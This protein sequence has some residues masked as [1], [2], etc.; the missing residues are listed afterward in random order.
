MNTIEQYRER[1]RHGPVGS[2]TTFLGAGWDACYG[3]QYEFRAD[4]TGHARAF[5]TVDDEE[6]VREAEFTWKLIEDFTIETQPVG[7]KI[8]DEDWGVIRYDFRFAYSRYGG[9]QLLVLYEVGHHVE[10]NP[11]FWWAP[12]PVVLASEYPRELYIVRP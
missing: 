2:W 6:P 4:F 12:N 11:G 1:F 5:D 10:D 7:E 3:E 8:C 9:D